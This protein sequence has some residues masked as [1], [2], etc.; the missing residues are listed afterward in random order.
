MHQIETHENGRRS[1][2][3][4][5]IDLFVAETRYVP[6]DAHPVVK[7]AELSP[8]LERLASKIRAPNA[9]RAWAAGPRIW[10]LDG[11]LTDSPGESADQPSLSLTFRD[12]DARPAAAGVWRRTAPGRW[13]PLQV[14]ASSAMSRRWH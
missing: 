1:R 14:F 5:C 11:W 12:H 13:E 8:Q 9:W 7:A 2:I 3:E 6:D 10:F 4:L